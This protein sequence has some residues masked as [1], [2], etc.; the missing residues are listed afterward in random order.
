MRA[1]LRAATFNERLESLPYHGR[2]F[3]NAGK[4]LR[5]GKQIVVNRNR[6]FHRAVSMHAM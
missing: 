5:L 1:S 4:F 2:L 3:G 6:S